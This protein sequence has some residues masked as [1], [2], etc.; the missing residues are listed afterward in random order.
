MKTVNNRTTEY[1]INDFFLKRYS[2]R[3][4][5]GEALTDAELLPLFEAARWAPSTMNMQ[6]WRFLYAIHGTADFNLFLSFLVEANQVWSKN[7][8]AIVVVLARKV[9]DNGQVSPVYSFDTGAACENLALQAAESGLIAHPMAG[10]DKEMVRSELV[11]PEDY[12]VE[13]MISIGKPGKIQDL[14]V[15]FQEREKP[16][17]RKNLNEIVFEGKNGAKSL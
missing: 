6:P 14:P 1:D 10:F 4:L 12:S 7:A 16:S 3:A 5:S 15:Q 8:G 17:N 9:M 2:P 11:I 13:V